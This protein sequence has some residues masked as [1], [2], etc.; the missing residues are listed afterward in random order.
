MSNDNMKLWNKV[1]VTNPEDTRDFPLEGQRLTTITAQSQVKRATELW[2]KYGEGWGLH[3]LK[4]S[5]VRNQDGKPELMMIEAVFYYPLEEGQQEFPIATD[6]PFYKQDGTLQFDMCKK[7]LTDARSKALSLL[8]FNADVYLGQFNDDK[9]L[10]NQ[11]MP[12]PLKEAKLS[13][14]TKKNFD[15]LKKLVKGGKQGAVKEELKR[16]KKNTLTLSL[17]NLIKEYE[18]QNRQSNK[19]PMVKEKK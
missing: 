17:E 1:C 5:V 19:R 14:M 16:Y 13:I 8:G 3:D 7:L 10:A 6:I 2:G 18:N 12:I 9:Y 4:Y 11:D 15:E